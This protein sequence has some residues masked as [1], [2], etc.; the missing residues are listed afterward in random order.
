MFA[1]GVPTVAPVAASIA[2][3]LMNGQTN[4]ALNLS[5][6]SI[7]TSYLLQ[8]TTNLASPFWYTETNFVAGQSAATVTES[9]VS[10]SA[11]FY[12]VVSY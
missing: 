2:A 8:S 7:G 10:N 4:V 6:L 11:K 12:R 5:G 1:F 9:A 3:G